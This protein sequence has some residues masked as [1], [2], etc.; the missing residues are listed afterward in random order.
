MSTN[1][2]I[3]CTAKQQYDQETPK[4]ENFLDN[5]N[6]NYEGINNSS[7]M[8]ISMIKN[9]L[10]KNNPVAETT[11]NINVGGDEAAEAV[12][13]GGGQSLSL[14]MSTA[15]SDK[16]VIEESSVPPRK[17]IDTFGQRTSIY[18]GV[19]RFHFFFF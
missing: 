15:A 6:I 7:T 9:W 12:G 17:S 4:L 10:I 1:S 14:G 2:S 5:N 16:S 11:D 19:T 8:G 3:S 13:G 18:R